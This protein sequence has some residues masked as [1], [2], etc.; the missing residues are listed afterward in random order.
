MQS[1]LSQPRSTVS[2]IRTI[3]LVSLLMLQ[4]CAH[5]ISQNLR[6]QADPALTFAELLENADGHRGEVVVLG[7]T[8]VATRN[9]ASGTEIEV[10]EKELS[11]YGEPSLSDDS[12]GRFIFVHPGYLESALFSKGR[13]VTGAGKVL[14][15]RLGKVGEREYRFPLI[16]IEEI[17]LWE[18]YT[19]YP[20]YYPYGYPYGF[21]YYYPF[22]SP[23]YHPYHHHYR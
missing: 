15:S 4:A 5:P 2:S 7:G 22:Y 11:S 20:Y 10:V 6:Q 12:R 21:P 3:L 1:F 16:A 14:G 18:E 23:F 19:Q 9:L 17:K 13:S 8:I